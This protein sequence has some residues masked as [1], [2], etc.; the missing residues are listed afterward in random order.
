M[1]TA[2]IVVDV[3]RDFCEGGSLAVEGGHAVAHDLAHFIQTKGSMFSTIVATKDWHNREGDNGGHFHDNPDYDDTWPGHCIASSPG[4]EFCPPLNGLLFDEIFL[5]G[6]DEP[7]Y[8]GF[9]GHGERHGKCLEDY[10]RFHKV[11]ELY[12]AGIAS[13]HCEKATVLTGLD[14]GF[15]VK[16][17]STMSVGVGGKA[18]HETALA[19]MSSKGAVIIR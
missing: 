18:A 19:E 1:S 15:I 7:A 16:V 12:V 14:K 2:L 8:D 9:Q 17:L 11:R 13:T 5:K 6:W 4:A 3:Q 10:L